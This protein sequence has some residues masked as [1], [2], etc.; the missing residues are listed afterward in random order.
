MRMTTTHRS[1]I[2]LPATIAQM[3]FS[4]TNK[5]KL[6]HHHTLDFLYSATVLMPP[7]PTTELCRNLIL[8]VKHDEFIVTRRRSFLDHCLT[9]IVWARFVPPAHSLRDSKDFEDLLQRPLRR[10]YA[11][12]L[13]VFRDRG[14]SPTNVPP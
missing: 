2:Y 6:C 4:P 10:S 5:L 11:D 8:H 13:I 9:K 3:F 12:F 14:A 7:A 1:G